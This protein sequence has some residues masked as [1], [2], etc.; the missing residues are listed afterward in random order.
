MRGKIFIAK[1]EQLKWL[2]RGRERVEG[3]EILSVEGR[4]A[5][6]VQGSV[7]SCVCL[8]LHEAQR[9]SQLSLASVSD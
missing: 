7:D 8:N 6:R 1:W 3:D 2:C 5:L 4:N 9:E